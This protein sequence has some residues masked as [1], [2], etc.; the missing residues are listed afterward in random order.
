[1]QLRKEGYEGPTETEYIDVFVTWADVQLRKIPRKARRSLSSKELLQQD[2]ETRRAIRKVTAA[3]EAGKNLT[4]HLSRKHLNAAFQDLLFNDWRI[5][6][7]HLGPRSGKR[8]GR[9]NKV[10]FAHV[11]DDVLYLIDA[12]DHRD[13]ETVFADSR[14]VEIMH[15][16]FPGVL[17]L[18]E[19]NIARGRDGDDI[20][21]DQRTRVRRAGIQTFVEIDGKIF[22]SPGGITTAGST[23]EAAK[24]VIDLRNAVNTLEQN[25]KA[26]PQVYAEQIFR[27]IGKRPSVLRFKLLV[28]G[29]TLSI[30][31]LNTGWRRPQMDIIRKR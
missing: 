27:D 31:E 16:N 28:G 3:S 23:A 11:T 20:D 6:H 22:G 13:D 14:L 5:H 26:N 7:L 24:F 1:M 17:P 18:V 19:M 29:D 30:E 4:P 9:T 8:T 21:K 2:E 15:R 10:L 12:M 25:I